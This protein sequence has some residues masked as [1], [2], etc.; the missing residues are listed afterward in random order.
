[1]GL[2]RKRKHRKRIA[3]LKGVTSI[4]E[5]LRDIGRTKVHLLIKKCGSVIQT[6]L[7]ADQYPSLIFL[8]KS[9]S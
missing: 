9:I 8:Y 4:E 3:C 5:Y 7:N 2:R 6:Q 1:L